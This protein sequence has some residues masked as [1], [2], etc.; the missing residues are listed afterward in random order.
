MSFFSR[1][2]L[3]SLAIVIVYD[4]TEPSP[5]IIGMA[6][7]MWPLPLRVKSDVYLGLKFLE[8][9][10]LKGRFQYEPTSE[11]Q[12]VTASKYRP[13]HALTSEM[14]DE[15]AASVLSVFSSDGAV[16]PDEFVLLD[17]VDGILSDMSNLQDVVQSFLQARA[18]APSRDS[19]LEQVMISLNVD[20]VEE[21]S[22]VVINDAKAKSER[23]YLRGR[24]TS[25]PMPS[26]NN[27][28]S[29]GNR[30]LIM[31]EPHIMF[32]FQVYGTYSS[33]A[34]SDVSSIVRTINGFG[35][36]L[37]HAINTQHNDL[38]QAIR[39]RTGFD[40]P[41][42]ITSS[43]NTNDTDALEAYSVIDFGGPGSFKTL[44]CEDR[45]PTFFYDLNE[46]ESRG[47]TN[48]NASL[49]ERVELSVALD[50][51][52]KESK[53]YD[54]YAVEEETETSDKFWVWVGLR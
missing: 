1:V 33:R 30:N 19:G 7:N 28:R 3:N 22:M 35:N 13:H 48:H 10:K 38:I 37:E 51:L 46:L 14:T 42:C 32:H 40:G 20:A 16:A 5:P 11:E 50:A 21:W 29:R 44:A 45:L 8:S 12:A 24:E 15:E 31:T 34:S 43:E 53:V 52:K 25:L 18:L 6:E 17:N 2:N 54:V 9:K 49:T 27:L 26:K 4:S 36:V 39:D 23:R 47:V 41:E